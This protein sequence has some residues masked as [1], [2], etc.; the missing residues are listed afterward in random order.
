MSSPVVRRERPSGGTQ[1]PTVL[2]LVCLLGACASQPAPA[3]RRAA[4]TPAA[5]PVRLVWLPVESLVAPAIAGSANDALARVRPRDATQSARAAVSMEVAQL[6]IECVQPTPACHAAVGRS[7]GA[8]RLLWVEVRAPA[9]VPAVAVALEVFDVGRGASVQRA[10]RTFKDA[11]AAG[12]GIATFIEQ[13]VGAKWE[14]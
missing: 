3:P 2:A 6:T 13:A 8:D 11:S 4:Q 5:G 12:A 1:L 9:G 10:E 7:L 14:P